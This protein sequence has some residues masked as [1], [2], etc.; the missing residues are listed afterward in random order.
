MIGPGIKSGKVDSLNKSGTALRRDS[1]IYSKPT[2]PSEREDTPKEHNYATITGEQEG[3][4]ESGTYSY[5]YQHGVILAHQLTKRGN[6]G[7]GLY[8]EMGTIDYMHM[9]SKPSP[10][11]LSSERS[12][13]P[14]HS[15]EER[16]YTQLSSATLDAKSVY[17]STV[18]TPAN[19][20]QGTAD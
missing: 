14:A 20:Y 13:G 17:T 10:L 7:N 1:T 6:E 12:A 3:K 9:Y 2:W 19:L 18:Q 4:W 11:L 8:Q 16:G 15:R 5:A